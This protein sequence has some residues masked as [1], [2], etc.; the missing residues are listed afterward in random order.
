MRH[1]RT[2]GNVQRL[3]HGSTDVPL[4]A[5][6]LRQ[7]ACIAERL[8]RDAAA[9]VL[10]SSPLSRA[11]TTA[12]VIG[13]RIGLEPVVVPE[14]TEMDF[15]TLEG[16]AIERLVEDHPEIAGRMLD[17]EDFDVAWP[18][19]ESRRGFYGRVLAAFLAVLEDYASH[20]VIVVAHGGVIGAFLAQAQG[21]SPNDP[22]AY[23]L[24]NC[25]LT[26]LQ[27]TAEHTVFHLRNDVV[28]LEVLDEADGMV[29]VPA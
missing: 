1:G 2:A 5:H 27:V 21:L 20:R 24:M 14:L 18:Q 13:D 29:E 19:G 12:R 28:H 23:D 8:G 17:M 10:L 16:A 26:Q 7:A 11:L 25:S 9:D 4:D 15:G 6:G 22:L 3:L